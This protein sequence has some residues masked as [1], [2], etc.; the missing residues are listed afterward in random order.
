MFV[1]D[2]GTCASCLVWGV[3]EEQL[4]GDEVCRS[5]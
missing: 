1:N 2:E 4:A 5:I 3:F